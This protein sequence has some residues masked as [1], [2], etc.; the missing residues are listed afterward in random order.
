MESHRSIMQQCSS[1]SVLSTQGLGKLVGCKCCMQALKA[2]PMGSTILIQALE[3]T[4]IQWI[5]QAEV[6]LQV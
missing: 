5:C 1:P 2:K 4:V 6:V 3:E